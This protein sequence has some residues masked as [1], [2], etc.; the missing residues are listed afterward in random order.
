MYLSKQYKNYYF[1]SYL[2]ILELPW[3]FPNIGH[4]W[5]NGGFTLTAWYQDLQ[6]CGFG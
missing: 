4:S 6:D 5:V 3:S 1:L 2:H